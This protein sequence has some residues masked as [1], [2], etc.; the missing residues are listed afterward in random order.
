MR[1]NKSSGK[2]NTGRL[3]GLLAGLMLAVLAG[4]SSVSAATLSKV[5]GF[6]AD[7]ASV[8]GISLSW[9]PVTGADGYVISVGS[10]YSKT[11]ITRTLDNR[12]TLDTIGEAPLSFGK[13]YTFY[14]QAYMTGEPE[15]GG[16][17]MPAENA[18]DG[19]VDVSMQQTGIV[20]GPY[21]DPLEVTVSLD[22]PQSF[23]AEG[24]NYKTV[25]LTWES[26]EGAQGYLIY[27][28]TRKNGPFQL[29]S[30]RKKQTA[31]SYKDK[32]CTTG[33]VYYYK[34]LSYSYQ[35]G[36]RV[37]SGESEVVSGTTLLKAPKLTGV[38]LVDA[39]T[40]A[41]SW[42]K[43]AGAKGYFV[44]RATSKKGL[45]AKVAVVDG[46]STVS[47]QVTGHENGKKYFYK[48]CAFGN[49][50]KKKTNS[51]FSN[52]KS[53]KFNLFASA[54]ETYMAKARRI[55]GSITY[56]KYQSEAE[57]LSHQKTITIAVWDFAADGVTKVTK[58]KTLTVHE[59]IAPTVQQIF[60][61]I[62]EGEEQFPIKSI[63]GYSWRG[64]TSSSEHCEGLAIDINWE[65]NYLI[66]NGTIITGKLYEP[67]VN[68]YS[69]PTDGEVARIMAK[70][71]FRQG[72]WGNRCDY[73]HFSYFGT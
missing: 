36:G 32:K 49:K 3:F 29:I 27:K 6:L 24:L 72:L 54:D 11:E 63:G 58:Y 13:I 66:D 26:V 65:E 60:K 62:Y 53:L 64:V 41:V 48:V 20:M 52:I 30:T 9:Q 7:A 45:Y 28:S 2:K 73:M 5:E 43:V 70:Y 69:I 18:A 71:G 67:G 17:L 12:V 15:Q 21:S 4:A 8:Q 35:N 56:R 44:Y 59:N 25:Q 34:I 1:Q 16:A 57:A 39:Q 14:V 61:E 10:A 31:V 38:S 42:K 19:N 23:A 68:P 46:A 22:T 37:L 50:K 33:V 47:A 51:A 55:F 40:A